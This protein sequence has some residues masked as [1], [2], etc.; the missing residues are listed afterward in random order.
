MR[1]RTVA[2]GT[3]FL[4]SAIALITAQ[5]SQQGNDRFLQGQLTEKRDGVEAA[6][7][8]YEE[9]LQKFRDDRVL[10]AKTKLQLAFCYETLGE[11]K[12]LQILKDLIKDYPEQTS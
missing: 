3:L 1:A 7:L 11:D 9:I 6:I 10:L 8:I 5:T 4:F 2:L 12:A